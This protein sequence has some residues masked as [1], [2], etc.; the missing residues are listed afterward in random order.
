MFWDELMHLNS[1]NVFISSLPILTTGRMGVGSSNAG[2]IAWV[3]NYCKE[4]RSDGTD[5]ITKVRCSNICEECEKKGVDEMIKCTHN[6]ENMSDFRDESNIEFMK[7]MYGKT[8][9]ILINQLYGISV[10]SYG[11]CYTTNIIAKLQ[12]GE[13]L[14]LNT[15]AP[16][17][18]LGIDPGKGHDY[19]GIVGVC[20]TRDA[21]GK[22]KLQVRKINFLFYR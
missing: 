18:T 1:K 17:I 20:P 2:K 8:P 10:R 6:R 11:C 15:R 16:V 4:K 9:E 5:L 3:D 19:T 14:P 21:N 7:K 13:R 12:V 22:H